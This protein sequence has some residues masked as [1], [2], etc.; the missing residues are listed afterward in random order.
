MHPFCEPNSWFVA[1]KLD[2]L[3]RISGTDKFLHYTK[4]KVKT[5]IIPMD[6]EIISNIE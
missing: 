6:Y 4:K 3:C 2:F 1:L 5:E